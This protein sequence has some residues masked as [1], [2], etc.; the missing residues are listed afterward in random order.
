[1]KI[2]NVMISRVNGG[3]EQMFLHYNTALGLSGNQV[4]S[5][6]D[7]KCLFKADIKKPYIEINF[8]K[9]N[10]LLIFRL[11]FALK[12][13]APDIIIVHQKKAIPIFKIVAYLLKAKIVGVAHNPKTKRLEKCD[14]VISITYNQKEKMIA[15][16]LAANKIFVV[17]NMVEVPKQIPQ[18]I[19]YHQPL[20]FGTM[21]RFEPAK[22][23]CDFIQALAY[24]KQKN[25]PFKAV[26]GGKNNSTYAEEEKRILQLVK[27]LDL[28][29]EVEF[30]GW[31]SDKQ[32]F[33]DGIDIFV[34]PSLEEAFG[35]VLLEAA[36]AKKP[37]IY[38]TAD[39][40]KEVFENTGAALMFEKGNAIMLAEKMAILSQN[41]PLAK[42]LAQK[43]YE[44]VKE[45]YIIDSGKKIL[46]S[47]LLE[48]L[49]K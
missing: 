38:S 23:F 26:I 9:Y 22:G 28:Q 43:A 39:G 21:G 5:V 18:Y 3:I 32:K 31:V 37:I 34:L 29:N 27:D 11:Y 8:N 4:M 46:Q 25:V 49:E 17:P 42:E 7:R 41:Q 6:I 13:F 47:T 1:M 30:C 19:P 24:L 44:L 2:A 15:Q 40:P 20:I 10:P 45:K 33:F 48:I 36:L 35:I 16:G 14:A 12:N